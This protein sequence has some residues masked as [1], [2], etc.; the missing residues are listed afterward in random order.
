MD[1][2]GKRDRVIASLQAIARHNGVRPAER[3]EGIHR[4]RLRN[5]VSWARKNAPEL[6]DI[7]PSHVFR[8]AAVLGDVGGPP[9]PDIAIPPDG[10]VIR[11][12]SGQ[13]DAD[14][15]L[16]KQWI[17]TGQ[18]DT[19]G[20]VAPAGHVIKGESVFLDAAGNVIGRWIKTRE[21]SGE[22]F[23]EALRTVFADFDGAARVPPAPEICNDDTLTVYPVPDLHLGMYAWGAETGADYDVAIAVQTAT[24]SISHLVR[25]SDPSRH[26]VALILGDFFHQNDQKNATPGSGHQLDVDTRWPLVYRAGAELAV[27]LVD[28][29]A[30][31]HDKVEVV[32]LPGNHDPDAAVTLAIA[33]S[34]FYSKSDRI[35]VNLTPGVAWYREFGL[36]LFGANHGHTIK[37]AEKMAAAMAIDA[38]ESWGRAKH[39]IIWTGHLHHEVMK[40]T[41]GVRVETLA[42]PAARD[43]WNA[44]SGYRAGR[45]LQGITFH[46]VHGEIG[47]HRVNISGPAAKVK[48]P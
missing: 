2:T 27:A 19:E 44:H 6:L 42:S 43:A 11:Q 38:H 15:K 40:E 4:D 21:G 24:E 12:N 18:G 1:D 8:A 23:V 17:K 10:F 26:A 16:Q 28:I 22:G 30:T 20:W 48:T 45:A 46:R 14:G 3:N 32:V 35:T 9:I 34:L 25:K 5:D 7:V 13:Y 36:N 29:V 47:R 33:L 41:Y 39:R 31:K 37:G